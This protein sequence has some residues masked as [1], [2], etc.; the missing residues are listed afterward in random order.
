MTLY[1][2]ACNDDTLATLEGVRLD[3]L[4]L[5][6]YGSGGLWAPNPLGDPDPEILA[7]LAAEEL[8]VVPA[9]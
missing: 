1:Y 7:K 2:Q 4:T 8:T 3:S 9:H 6:P 5:D